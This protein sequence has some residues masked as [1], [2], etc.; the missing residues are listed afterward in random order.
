MAR[1]EKIPHADNHRGRTYRALTDTELQA[2]I[3]AAAQSLTVAQGLNGETAG[4]TRVFL[5]MLAT[6]FRIRKT[7][8]LTVGD[9]DFAEI[10]AT[11]DG[12]RTKNH[13]LA[14]QHLLREMKNCLSRR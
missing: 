9:F 11:L 4:E 13:K 5:F 2:L 6:G 7:L 1:I 3:N 12:S 10:A 14:V 8:R